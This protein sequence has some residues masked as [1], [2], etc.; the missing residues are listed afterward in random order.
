MKTKK[1]ALKV[2]ENVKKL[3]CELCNRDTGLDDNEIRYMYYE[4]L[5]CC[6]SCVTDID[7]SDMNNKNE[8]ELYLDGSRLSNGSNTFNIMIDV[9]KKSNNKMFG[10]RWDF[11]FKFG[12]KNWHGVK[13]GNDYFNVVRCKVK[14]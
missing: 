12:S 2:V 4:N 10:D 14:K 9:M 7:K 11:W 1:R 8:I 13:M 3:K 5:L 6:E